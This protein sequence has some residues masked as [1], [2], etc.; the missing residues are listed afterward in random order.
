VARR[1]ILIG[2]L[3]RPASASSVLAVPSTASDVF[4]ESDLLASPIPL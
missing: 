4:L 2:G 3:R 1:E